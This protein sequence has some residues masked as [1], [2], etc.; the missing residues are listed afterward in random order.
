MILSSEFW[1]VVEL[2]F[3][4]NFSAIFELVALATTVIFEMRIE[5]KTGEGSLCVMKCENTLL[6]F[7]RNLDF[8]EVR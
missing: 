2:L 4:T 1:V 5:A 7:A 6:N 8:I 3:F